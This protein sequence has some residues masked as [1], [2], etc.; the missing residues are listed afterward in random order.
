M[1]S[2][3]TKKATKMVAYKQ[4]QKRYVSMVGRSI[5]RCKIYHTVCYT[6]TINGITV[7]IYNLSN[8]RATKM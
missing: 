4:L 5:Y 3:K 7:H 1:E 6:L 2:V 8:K